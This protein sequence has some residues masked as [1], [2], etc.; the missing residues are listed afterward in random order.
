MRLVL[1]AALCAIMAMATV[2]RTV[3]VSVQDPLGNLIPNLRPENFALY[4]NDLDVPVAYDDI[5]EHLRVRYVLSYLSS[6]PDSGGGNV[7][8]ELVDP[9]TGAPL[10]VA[11]ASGR[12]I[13]P[14]VTVSH[15]NK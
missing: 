8:V 9:R 5:M 10:R 3:V 2:T 11:D 14:T 12:R 4:E 6:G 1:V 7:R 13:T 15:F